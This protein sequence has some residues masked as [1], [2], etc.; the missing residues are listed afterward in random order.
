[1][2]LS[3][4]LLYL[5]VLTC[6]LFH[7]HVAYKHTCLVMHVITCIFYFFL[8]N[9]ISP[10][11]PCPVTLLCYYY[12][13]TCQSCMYVVLYLLAMDTC[14][15][16]I[17]VTLILNIYCTVSMREINSEIKYVLWE[18]LILLGMHRLICVLTP[19]VLY[20]LHNIQARIEIDIWDCDLW[21]AQNFEFQFFYLAAAGLCDHRVCIL[22]YITPSYDW[23]VL[24][25]L[26]RLAM[27]DLYGD[28][29]CSRSIGHAWYTSR[30]FSHHLV[31]N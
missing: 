24:L 8:E 30:A 9:D 7:F 29:I 21:Y 22:I 6:M 26:L 20:L 17:Y 3:V 12:S 19:S 4:L 10:T 1:M 2:Y 5:P 25:S 14:T 15:L 16:I 27:A 11:W 23:F 31:P 28:Q 13:C 18:F